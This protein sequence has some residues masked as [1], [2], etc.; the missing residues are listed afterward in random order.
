MSC[1]K[2]DKLKLLTSM[3]IFGTIGVVR[4]YI[5]YPSSVIALVRG[6]VGV[7]FL[8]LVMAFKKEKI[9]GS[10][11]KKNAVLLCVSGVLLG[12]NWILL[13]EAYRYTSVAAAT[14]CYYMAPV[15]MILV[16]PVVLHEPLTKKKSICAATAVAGMVLVSG[17]LE[18]GISGAR[19]ILF[20]LGAAVLYAC[21]VLL[22]K[23][24]NDISANDRTICQLGI[25]AAAVF[26]Y[27]LATEDLT[28]LDTSGAV[29][30][31]LLVAGIVH[32]GIS[33]AMYFDS[34]KNIP[35]QTVA[36]F[37][38]ID[39]VVAVILSVAVLK[40]QMSILA[41][42]GVVLVIGAAVMNELTESRS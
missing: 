24:I 41:I 33:Y 42:I 23:F 1:F 36:I 37:S 16:S 20:G 26:P 4:R 18:T 34:V 2:A 30:I 39:P 17:I 5:P 40:E 11:I 35:A 28:G 12:T 15:I 27:V 21:I 7:L 32:T 14:M 10:A 9:S 31:M 22:N 6:G 13:F 8:L 38:Y 3:V 19:G 25:S 29:L